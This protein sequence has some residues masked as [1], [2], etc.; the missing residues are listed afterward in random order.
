MLFP[1]LPSR[2]KSSHQKLLYFLNDIHERY[3]YRRGIFTEHLQ[4]HI[5]R[6]RLKHAH[7]RD[8][9]KLR[10]RSLGDSSVDEIYSRRYPCRGD[11]RA[12]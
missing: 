11:E 8:A 6:M 4:R 10:R 1:Y 2:T 12:V 7:N 3:I 5:G 9:E